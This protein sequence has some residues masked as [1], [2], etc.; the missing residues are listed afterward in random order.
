VIMYSGILYLLL[1]QVPIVSP[2]IAFILEKSIILMNKGL[3]IIEHIPF[4]S[5]G[6]IW[7]TTPEYLLLYIVIIGSFYF[8]YDRKVW[9]L[10]MSIICILLLCISISVKRIS[11]SRNRS[12]AFLNLKKHVGI[13]FKNGNEAVVLSD[14]KDN[15]K[16]Y[17]YS[18]QPY[19]DSSKVSDI[20]LLELN[21]DIRTTWLLKKNDLIQFLNK[22]IILFNGQLQSNLPQKLKTDYVYLTGNPTDGINSVNDNFNYQT[23]IIDGSNSD[24]VISLA[25]KQD[26]RKAYEILKRNN[27]LILISY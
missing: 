12:I 9:L 22:R 25:E 18:I 24:K 11:S 8:L 6:K 20:K 3:A 10:K 26:K 5:I 16:T 4:A 13:V 27:S 15:D 23:L 2:S 21:V 1:P 17:Q 7:L 19:L 14:I